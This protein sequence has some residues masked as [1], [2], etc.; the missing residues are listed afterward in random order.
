MS[1][2]RPV[3]LILGAT[4]GVGQALSALL[5]R[6]G[7]GLV[8]G[9]RDPV[10]LSELC[11]P[12]AATPVE[13]DARDWESVDGAFRAA[14][15]RFGR[16]DAVANLVGSLFLKPAHLTRQEDLQDV[17][18]VNLGSA[19]GCVRA[20]ARSLSSEAPVSSLVLVSSAAATLGLANHEAIAAAKAG[21]EGLTRSAAATYAAKGLRVNAVAPGLTKTP[22]TKRL[23]ASDAAAASSAAMHPLGSLGEPEDVASAIAW[24]LDPAQRWVTGQVLGVDGGLAAVRPPTVVRP[25]ASTSA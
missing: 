2:E 8:L 11:Q 20:A 23:W 17:L 6:A 22:L 15:E 18:E 4:G 24:F 1:H 7:W 14:V 3:A 10:K 16:L 25:R 19:F 12:L 5:H 9:G 21:V 13:V